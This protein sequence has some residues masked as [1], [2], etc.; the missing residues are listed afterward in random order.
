L[1]KRKQDVFCVYI[2]KMLKNSRKK[3]T[4][5]VSFEYAQT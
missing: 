5:K 4:V 1:L 3:I 2:N